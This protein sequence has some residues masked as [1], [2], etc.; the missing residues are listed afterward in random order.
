[1]DKDDPVVPSDSPQLKYTTPK[2]QGSQASKVADFPS[3]IRKQ[4]SQNDA[5]ALKN[6]NVANN[7]NVFN[8]QLNYDIDQALDQESWDGNFR[9]ISLH[10][11]MKH[12]ASDIKNI[13]E[14]LGRM[15]RYILGKAIEG[16]KANDIK[17]L[18][19]VGKA[20]WGFILALYK[21]HWDNLM[22]DSTNISFRNNIKSKFS[23]QVNKEL[24]N[25]KG[26]NIVN[27]S[28]V[29]SFPPPISAKSAKEVNE[30]SKFFK[31]NNNTNQK[32]LYA[33][34][35]SNSSNIARETL[36]IKEAFLSL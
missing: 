35:L 4:H 13:K 16:N 2:S 6:I 18:K 20:T 11:S 33:Q 1:M 27:H 3:N 25:S 19:G 21:S 7:N 28:Y 24:T 5:S 31:K 12:L 17:D 29:S 30:I 14:S 34:V 36:K 22:V 8:I 9:A 23:L 32:K 26:K 15:Q 10:R